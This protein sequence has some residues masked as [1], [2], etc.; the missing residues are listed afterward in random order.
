[1]ANGWLFRELMEVWLWRQ[2]SRLVAG[3]RVW[4]EAKRR[5]PGFTAANLFWWF[6]MASSVDIAVTP[7]PIYKADGRK[8]PDCYTAPS[9]LR[10][11]LN[12][13]LGPFPLFDF[14]GP[15]TSIRST[16]WIAD[17]AIHV[18]RRRDP[19]L[20]L[21]YL[22]HLDYGLQRHGPYDPAIAKDLAEIDAVAGTLIAEATRLGREVIVLSEYGIVPIRRPVH[23]NR[24]LRQAGLLSVRNEEGGELLDIPQSRAFA[25]ADHQIAHVYVAEPKVLDDVQ[26]VL[27]QIDG[28]DRVLDRAGKQ[29]FGI[30]H[31][32]SGELVVLAKSDAWFSYYYWLDDAHA[33][34]FARTV[35]IHRKPG[36]DPVELFLDPAIG[37]PKFAIGSRLLKKA[38]GFRT[39]MDVIPL[40][41]SL[42]KGS[43]G[44]ADA[45]EREGPRHLVRAGASAA[46]RR[47]R[48]RHQD[49]D[50][51]AHIRHR[52]IGA[53][54]ERR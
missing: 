7:R 36:Y 19:T 9:D 44:R 1:M 46:G 20:T 53:S 22:P 41:A 33:P 48:H 15:A 28:V 39:L 17:A 34:D 21:V 38:L 23:V 25:V 11:E 47:S 40:D 10:D 2:S 32:R 14:W 4:E 35:D 16:Q 5:D 12:A 6:A 24:V 18:M 13:R 54:H 52:V 31:D 49:A 45:G 26:H 8:L 3:E 29:E 50:T 51:C 43:H 42:V 37:F 27:E 30:D